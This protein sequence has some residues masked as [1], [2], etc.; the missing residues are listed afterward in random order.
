[1]LGSC[2]ADRLAYQLQMLYSG[3]AEAAKLDRDPQVAAAQR[4]AVESLLSAALA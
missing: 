4:T 1:L 3:G 2:K